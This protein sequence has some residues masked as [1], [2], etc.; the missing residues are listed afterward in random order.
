MVLRERDDSIAK[1]FGLDAATRG[2]TMPVTMV[3]E[4]QEKSQHDKTGNQQT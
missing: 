4:D 2:A 1:A 3:S